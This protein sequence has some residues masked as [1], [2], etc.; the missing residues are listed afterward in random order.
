MRLTYV[1]DSLVTSGGAEQALAQL[2]PRWIAQG[3][4]V[5]VVTLIGPQ[6]GL[7]DVLRAQG[8]RVLD[9]DAARMT[10]V[11]RLVAHL[12]AHP[13]DLIHTTLFEADLVG[14]TAGALTGTPVVTSLVNTSYGPEHRADPRLSPA[15]LRAAQ[16]TDVVSARVVRRFHAITHHVSQ[17]M[18]RRLLLAGKPVD[19]VPRGRDPLVLGE[20]NV[21][22][23]VRV[24]SALG[25]DSGTPLLLVAARQEHQKGV[26]VLLDA[27]HELPSDVHLL[28]A[29]RSGHATES[30]RRQASQLGLDDRL[31]WLGTRD[32]IPDLMAAADVVVVPSRWEGLGSTV[33]EA[34]GVGTPI[35]ASDVPAVRETLG[36]TDFGVLV[37]PE[38]PAALAA[39]L[40]QALMPGSESSA[41]RARQRFLD[42]YTLDAVAAAMLR[43]HERALLR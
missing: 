2:A 38:R 30:L 4:Q 28:L 15:R 40:R 22:R 34:M 18:R 42:H 14:R 5:H 35:V 37:A 8:A 3:H 9:L 7:P 17:V 39:G 36:G 16:A 12:R 21:A 20:R 32:D 11:R 19:V 31:T 26:D 6:T 25:L 43:F 24:R 33:V 10:G 29:G 13:T 23:R 41:V 27:L 1:I